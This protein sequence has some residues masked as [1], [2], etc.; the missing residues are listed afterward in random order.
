MPSNF[1]LTIM[2][3]PVVTVPLPQSALDELTT[4]EVTNTAERGKP[5]GFRLTFNLSRKSPLHTIFL[6]AGS[7]LP[8]IMRVIIVATINGTPNVLMD[9]VI[10]KQ[11]VTPGAEQSNDT[12]TVTGVDISVVMNWIDFSGIPYPAMPI[13]A[14]VLV[15]LAKYAIFGV[16]PKI[17]PTIL[18]EAPIPTDKIPKQKGK[19][20]AYINQLA[21]EVGYIFYVEPGPSP[22]MN[23]AYFGPE[24]KVGIPQKALS[25]NMDAHTNVESLSF[26]LDTEEKTLPVT[27]IQELLSKIP[28]P[29]PLPDINPLNPLLG[30]IPLLTRQVEYVKDSAKRSPIQ[31]VLYGLARAGA[32]ADGVTGRGKL[33]VFRYGRPLEARKLV[34]VRGAGPAFDGLH[35]V[36][37][38]THSIKRGEY[39]QEFK[40]TRNGLLST[41]PSVPV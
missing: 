21:E 8:P 15:I 17:I 22:G 28:I 12:L 11:E 29:I 35:Y 37:Q 32:S 1:T 23:I 10:T 25:I 40:L 9:G 5:S 13:E 16:V 3:G 38:V 31:A 24:I 41:L 14:R 33:D 7:S 6:L 18:F 26:D 19:D 30:A 20:L 2:V 39:K 36:Q 4:V 27:F 34:G